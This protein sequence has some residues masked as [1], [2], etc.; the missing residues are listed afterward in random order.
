MFS[1]LRRSVVYDLSITMVNDTKSVYIRC[2]TSHNMCHRPKDDCRSY[3]AVQRRNEEQNQEE[4]SD[5]SFSICHFPAPSFL[6]IPASR[7]NI[8]SHHLTSHQTKLPTIPPNAMPGSKRFYWVKLQVAAAM[9]RTKRR[10]K[11]ISEV[12]RQ[13]IDDSHCPKLVQIEAY[14]RT[15]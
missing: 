5:R 11:A 4:T 14:V 13:L 8:T 3:C 1:V 12:C 10:P 6:T 15:V 2:R 9:Y 7:H